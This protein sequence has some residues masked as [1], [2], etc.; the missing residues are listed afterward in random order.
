MDNNP[1]RLAEGTALLQAELLEQ[2]GYGTET[3][4]GRLQHIK[5]NKSSEQKPARADK[6]KPAL[7]RTMIPA[8]ASTAR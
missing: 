5:S 3:G 2:L 8:N 6:S 4:K 1:T 7:T